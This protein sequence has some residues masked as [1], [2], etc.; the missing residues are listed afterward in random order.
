MGLFFYY[1]TKFAD[2]FILIYSAT[3]FG[4]YFILSAF[5]ALDIMKY[6]RKNSFIDYRDILTAPSAPSISIIAPA[7]NESATIVENVRSL[8]NIHYVNFEVII[9]NDGSK[10]NTLQLMIDAYELE[11]VEYAVEDKMESKPI[12]AVY[13]SRIPS[14]NKL[15]VVDKVNGGKADALNAGINV[16]KYDIFAAIDVDC[17]LEYESL[18]KMVKPFME[19]TEDEKVIAVGGVVRIANSCEV[20]DGKIIQVNLPKQIIPRIQ[21]LE[22]IRA[23]LLGRMAWSRLNGLILI[24]GA[25]GMFDKKIAIASGGYNHRTVG[26]DM[27]LVIRMRKYMEEKKKAYRVV[28]LPDPLCWT[29]APS[30]LKILSKQR[31]RWTR[32]TAETLWMHK[33]LIFNPKYKFLGMISMPFWF[34]FEWLAPIVESTAFLY[35]VMMAFLGIL[36]VELFITLFVLIYTFAL[37][38]STFAILFEELSFHQYQKKRD[39]FRLLGTAL[40]EPLIIHPLTV[41]YAIRGNLDLMTG[42][43]NWGEMK[44]KGFKTKK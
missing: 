5:S 8:L 6:M 31:N 35:L 38:Y 16:S 2:H 12:R 14:I 42:V 30:S 1:F 26:E 18:L 20:K 34:L 9:V 7:Y 29:E 24:S 33:K 39:I 11:P 3:L 22:Y 23:F 21:V 43:R 19:E 37:L 25:F 32:G 10:D 36:N 13:K 27:E 41:Y 4:T 15:T 28:Y 44:R 40:I 17:I